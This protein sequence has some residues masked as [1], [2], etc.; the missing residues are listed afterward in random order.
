VRIAEWRGGEL[1]VCACASLAGFQDLQDGESIT[2]YR[3][4]ELLGSQPTGE[5][6][7]VGW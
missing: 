5:V 3:G 7:V 6:E 4:R 1:K 2:G